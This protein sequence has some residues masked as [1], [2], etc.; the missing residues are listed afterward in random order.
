MQDFYVKV[1]GKRNT[2]Q[3]GVDIENIGNLLNHKWG[4]YKQLNST[5][6]LNYS[7]GAYHFNTNN[8]ERLT[9]SFRNYQ[10][11]NSTYSVQFSLRYIFN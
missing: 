9:S 11:F 8:G 3:F 6:I 2:L 7:N 10:S 5:S 1:G 4:L